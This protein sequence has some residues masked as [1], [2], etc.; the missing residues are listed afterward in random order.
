[1]TAAAAVPQH[2]TALEQANST[3][4]QRARLR[5][6]ISDAGAEDGGRANSRASRELLARML[7]DPPACVRS[8]RLE[9]V[10]GWAH[11]SGPQTAGRCATD[12]IALLYPGDGRIDSPWLRTQLLIKPIGRLT[13][14][15][16]LAI[17][18]VLRGS[19]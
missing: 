12:V 3:R 10:L 8:A 5:S 17:T 1:M 18:V 11:R 7:E 14:R 15:E 19:P 16:R 6:V 2:M 4:L 13:V 9:T